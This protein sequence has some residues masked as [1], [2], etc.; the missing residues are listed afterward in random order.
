MKDKILGWWMCLAS[1]F[2]K[3]SYIKQFIIYSILFIV[4]LLVAVIAADTSISAMIVAYL[5][6]IYAFFVGGF[7]MVT[8]ANNGKD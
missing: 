3:M 7:R 5:I 8:N 4:P 2:I 6:C 1:K